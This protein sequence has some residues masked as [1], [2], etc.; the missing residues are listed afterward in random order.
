MYLPKNPSH[1]HIALGAG[2]SPGSVYETLDSPIIYEIVLIAA[3]VAFGL[4]L[5]IILEFLRFCT[6]G[7][8]DVEEGLPD[9]EEGLL[10]EE[11][12]AQPGSPT[13]SDDGTLVNNESD[14][15]SYTYNGHWFNAD[16][17]VSQYP[18]PPLPLSLKRINTDLATGLK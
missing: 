1:H 6:E 2:S 3:V 10:E 18:H 17:Y 16:G 5:L 8:P 13:L 15:N 7:L 12:E 11:E 9:V 4:L 14:G